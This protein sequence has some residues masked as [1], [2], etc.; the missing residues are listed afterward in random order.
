MR[1][2]RVVVYGGNDNDGFSRQRTMDIDD[3]IVDTEMTTPEWH[4]DPTESGYF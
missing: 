4:D 1:D 3:G 2:P